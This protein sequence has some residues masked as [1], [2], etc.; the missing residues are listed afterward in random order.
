LAVEGFVSVENGE[1]RVLATDIRI[2]SMVETEIYRLFADDVTIAKM[3]REEAVQ[4][5]SESDN[6]ISA[7]RVEVS[8]PERFEPHARRFS[9]MTGMEFKLYKL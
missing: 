3:I 7:V 9:R 2:P 1:T 6:T 5:D 8:N 4:L